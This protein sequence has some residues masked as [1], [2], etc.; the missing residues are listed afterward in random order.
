MWIYSFS[1]LCDFN[2]LYVKFYL[3]LCCRQIYC[4]FLFFFFVLFKLHNFTRGLKTTFCLFLCSSYFSLC[5]K[6]T[7]WGRFILTHR[8]NNIQSIIHRRDGTE[9]GAW[10][11][12]SHIIISQESEAGECQ[13]QAPSSRVSAHETTPCTFRVGC[14][15]FLSLLRNTLMNMSEVCLLGNSQSSQ[16]TSKAGP[17]WPTTWEGYVFKLHVNMKFKFHGA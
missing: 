12:Q 10:D 15:S 8:I 11:T 9:A 3:A 14:T 7:N 13:R 16:A 1:P 4:F 6:K 2:S 17:F 5:H